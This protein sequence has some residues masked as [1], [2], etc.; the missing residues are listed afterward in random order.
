MWL[1]KKF[2]LR[3]KAYLLTES[4]MIENSPVNQILSRFQSVIRH[5]PAQSLQ[6]AP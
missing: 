3:P 6:E 2:S 1:A 5:R 4:T